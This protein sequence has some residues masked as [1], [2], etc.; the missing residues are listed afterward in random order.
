MGLHPGQVLNG[1]FE[2]G[3][4]IGYGGQGVVLRVKHLEW[5]RYLALKLPLPEVVQTP[6]N[7]ERYL[8]EA[9]TWIRMGA[10]PHIVRCWFV[11]QVIGLPGL[12][13]DLITGGSLEDKMK[14]GLVGPGHWAEI[15]FTLLQVAE[16][17]THSH[18]MGVVHRDIKP[19]NLLITDTGKVVLTD[20]GL[21]KAIGSVEPEATGTDVFAP[22]SA[23]VTGFGQFVGTPRYGAPEQWNKAMMV[24]PA[25][26]IYALGVLFFELLCGRRPFDAPGEN[27]DPLELIQRHL[28]TPAPDPRTFREDVPERLAHLA[29]RCLSKQSTDRPQSAVETI[30]LLSELLE[31][32]D[33][34]GFERPSPVFGRRPRRSPEQR[35]RLPLFLGQS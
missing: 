25:T 20:F 10:H 26:D 19:E 28:H 22:K 6:V 21:V 35:G 9:E 2:V 17:L 33:H 14:D 3:N 29:L 23:G 8:Q 30:G 5:G 32:Y 15:L 4:L 13:L 16:G 7:R 12:F 11:H 18:A 34:P 24:G 1:R 27:P 31:A